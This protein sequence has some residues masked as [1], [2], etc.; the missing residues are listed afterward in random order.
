MRQVSNRGKVLKTCVSGALLSAVLGAPGAALAQAPPYSFQTIKVP[1]SLGTEA[2][3]IN[4]SGVVVGTFTNTAGVQHGFKFDGGGYTIIDFPGATHSWVLGIGHGG[5]IV[6][7]HSFSGSSGPWHSFLLEDGVYTQFDFP[8][9]ESDGR[10]I[11]ASGDIVGVYNAGGNLPTHGFVRSANDTY[12]TLDYPGALYTF[13]W[14]INDA[15]LISGTYINDNDPLYTRHG[16]IRAQGTFTTIDYP[17]AMT[18]NVIGTNNFGHVVGSHGQVNGLHGFVASAG[19]FR[20]FD[21]PGATTTGPQDINDG[22]QIVGTYYSA[23]CPRGCGFLARPQSG[24]PRCTQNFSLGYSPGSLNLQY[25]LGTTVPTTWHT[26]VV[27]GGTWYRLWSLPLGTVPLTGPFTV[28]VPLAPA[29]R[30]LALSA[31]SIAGT[32]MIC[33]DYSVVDTGG[34]P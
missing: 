18:T 21:V 1:G 24:L 25:T 28:P 16:F 2:Y 19:R 33:A 8:G 22:G 32:G 27:V 11:N 9:W 17:G 5:E 15:G 12:T 20:S 23:D 30:V 31:L 6:G 13:P 34:T 10:S 29:G 7:S 26:W 4:N 3:S 14:G